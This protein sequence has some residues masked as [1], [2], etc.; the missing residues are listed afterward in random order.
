MPPVVVALIHAGLDLLEREPQRR[1]RLHANVR[2]L[3]ERLKSIGITTSSQSAIVPV[4]IPRRIRRVS[5]RMHQAG[6]FINAVEYPA[7]PQ[8]NERFRISVISEHTDD[9]IDRLVEALDLALE[10]E[11]IDRSGR[12]L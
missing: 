4:R 5:R 12:R 2:H 11:G 10:E 9:D 1:Q 8:D 7:V 6:I 3:T